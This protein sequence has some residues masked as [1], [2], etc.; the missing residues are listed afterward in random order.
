MVRIDG[1]YSDPVPVIPVVDDGRGAEI[2]EDRFLKLEFGAQP[3]RRLTVADEDHEPRWSLATAR[4]SR[5]RR[6]TSPDRKPVLE[7]GF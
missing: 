2:N 5:K 7:A 6:F 3:H 4:A 1:F